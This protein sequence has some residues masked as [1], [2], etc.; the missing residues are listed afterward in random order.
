MVAYNRDSN[1]PNTLNEPY[2]D[3]DSPEEEPRKEKIQ[4]TAF[5]AT[6]KRQLKAALIG[7]SNSHEHADVRIPDFPA[8][9]TKLSAKLTKLSANRKVHYSARHIPAEACIIPRHD[10]VGPCASSS[11]T[12]TDVQ[13]YS[14]DSSGA[15]YVR[16]RAQAHIIEP[17]RSQDCSDWIL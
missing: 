8:K 15:F 10:Q 3:S 7:H 11:V 6:T 9:L 17:A 16:G 5:E 13:Q 4:H 1:R 12:D 2:Y 14:T